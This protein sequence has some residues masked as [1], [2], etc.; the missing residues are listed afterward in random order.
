MPI[1]WDKEHGTIVN[2]ESADIMRMFNRWG[3]RTVSGLVSILWNP[4]LQSSTVGFCCPQ[5]ALAGS[6]TAHLIL[7]ARSGQ[8]TAP[9]GLA[10]PA[11]PSRSSEADK[12]QA[13]AA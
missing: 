7:V 4:C 8:V 2:N 10:N 3:A 9:S 13:R 5:A 6:F 12:L 1:L 11:G